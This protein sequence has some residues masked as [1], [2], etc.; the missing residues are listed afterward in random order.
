MRKH[1]IKTASKKYRIP[2]KKYRNAKKKV[3]F[4]QSQLKK[5]EEVAKSSNTSTIPTVGGIQ[6]AAGKEIMNQEQDYAVFNAF[7]K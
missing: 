6:S 7:F 2:S 1:Q 4:W 3:E 5:A